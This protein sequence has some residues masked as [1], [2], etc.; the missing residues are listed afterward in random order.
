MTLLDRKVILAPGNTK[1]G[2]VLN[3]SLPP[4]KSCD[5]GL[6]CFAGGC[7]ANKFYALRE[8][9]RVAW[10]SNWTMVS[11]ARTAY[12]TRIGEAV[13]KRKTPV[14]RWH[15]AGDI[16][17]GDYLR[18]MCGLA[19][20]LPAVKWLCFTKKYDLAGLYRTALPENL[21]VVLSMW[22]GVRVPPGIRKGFPAAWMRDP[23]APDKR[24]PKDAVHC[25]GGCD[26]CLLCWGM[27]P[28]ASVVFDKH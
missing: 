14:F 22:P 2:K 21:T 10:E 13:V 8:A 12:F 4:C 3:V 24:I 16:P 5:T 27:K 20:E 18:R 28:G 7:Y 1:M 25:D 17:D 15:M 26:K 23:K 6:P 9:C 11:T 19:R